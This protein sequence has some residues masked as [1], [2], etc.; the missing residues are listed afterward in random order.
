MHACIE[1]YFHLATCGSFIV[2]MHEDGNQWLDFLVLAAS[3]DVS[4]QPLR[5]GG[6]SWFISSL[7]V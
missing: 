5:S 2:G 3:G 1:R 6:S 4:K 7:H